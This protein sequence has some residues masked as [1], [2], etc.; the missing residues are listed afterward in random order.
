MKK[1]KKSEETP[2]DVV[3]GMIGAF[4]SIQASVEIRAFRL[5]RVCYTSVDGIH[6]VQCGT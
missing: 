1:G 4:S 5:P 2:Y 3:V 6:D